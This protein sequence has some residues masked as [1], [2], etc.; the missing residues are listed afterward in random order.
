MLKL[1]FQQYKLQPEPT[2]P[3]YWSIQ[4]EIQNNDFDTLS[5]NSI[6][7]LNELY[8]DHLASVTWF[9]GAG[10]ATFIINAVLRYTAESPGD[11]W[12]WANIL[13]IGGG[14]VGYI[15]LSILDIKS[16]GPIIV[17]NKTTDDLKI[18]SPVYKFADSALVLPSFAILN[19]LVLLALGIQHHFGRLSSER[20]AA[21][22]NL[23]TEEPREYHQRMDSTE[24]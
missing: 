15:L 21:S 18:T 10:G 5:N 9:P 19:L 14:G 4:S 6:S 13:T 17:F 3:L 12:D 7:T 8:R 20:K 16:G 23:N 2:E 22:R 1:F 11:K 24:P